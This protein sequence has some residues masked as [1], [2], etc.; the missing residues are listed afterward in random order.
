[1]K[2]VHINLFIY[3]GDPQS[4]IYFCL[5][6]FF[7]FFQVGGWASSWGRGVV[8]KNNNFLT[9]FQRKVW[10]PIFCVL[11]FTK[12]Y[13]L[14]IRLNLGQAPQGSHVALFF[15]AI[16]HWPPNTIGSAHLVH[17]A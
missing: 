12:V 2:C 17:E 16:I 14:W 13:P 8:V 4:A 9:F 6:G 1:M 10:K 5:F 3:F 11:G 7:F 15:L